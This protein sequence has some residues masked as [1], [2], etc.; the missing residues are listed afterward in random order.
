MH[1]IGKVKMNI[2]VGTQDKNTIE[3]RVLEPFN[4]IIVE[5]INEVSSVLLKDKNLKQYPEM[6]ALGFWMRKSHIGKLKEYFQ[7]SNEDKI[8]LGRGVVFHIAPSNVDTIFIY[9][10]FLSMLCGNSNIVRISSK[11]NIQVTLLISILQKTLEIEKFQE[12]QNRIMIVKYG[13][14][15]AITSELSS[16]A[17]VR[18]IWGGD[19][20]IEHIRTLPIKSTATELTFADK[21]SFAMI[22]AKEFLDT[23]DVSTIIK[24]IYND[25]YMFGQMA[26]SSTRMIVWVGETQEN[27]KAKEKFWGIFNAYVMEQIPDDIVAADIMNKYVAECS[28]AIESKVDIKQNKNPYV[29]RISIANIN[30]VKEELHCGVGLFYELETGSLNTIFTDVSKKYQTI[31]QYGFT[32]DELVNF[33]Y[34]NKPLGIDRIVNLGNGLEFSNIWDGYDLFSS[35]TREIE[36]E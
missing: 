4:P 19:A 28:M 17:D 21:F 6:V 13:Y 34:Q 7:K 2:V 32:R 20:T 35:L 29:N 30:E 31:T 16:L 22:N 9:S 36:V 33:I 15:D 5:Y 14:D 24:N 3:K 23:S 26:C 18:V 27:D 25:T 12:L 11:D 8:L 10:L 1:L